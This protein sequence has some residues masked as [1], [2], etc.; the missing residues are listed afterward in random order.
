[1]SGRRIRNALLLAIV[2]GIGYWIYTDR[3]TVS[4]IVDSIT[5][6]LFGSK[7]AVDSSE[8]NRVR[9]D[10]SA[11]VAE[12]TDARTVTTL[13]EGMS[14]DEIKD[15]LGKPDTIDKLKTDG[16]EQ[17]R[18]TYK[19]ARRVIVFEGNRVVSISVL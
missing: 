1:M 3:P 18:W 10:A 8:H 11:V 12:Q 15:L 14:R 6:P 19:D 7:A 2:V 13:R 16:V 17:Q 5:R 4:G 9:D